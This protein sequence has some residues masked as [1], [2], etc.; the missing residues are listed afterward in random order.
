MPMPPKQPL[1]PPMRTITGMPAARVSSSARITSETAIRPALA[2]CS[3]RHPIRRVEH[4]VGS[5]AQGA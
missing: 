2:S 1:A 3:E 5:V 4:R